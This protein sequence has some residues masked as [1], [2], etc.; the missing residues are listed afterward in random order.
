MT[1][2]A[3]PRYGPAPRARQHGQHG[4]VTEAIA[5][6]LGL[7][8]ATVRDY[9][10]GHHQLGPLVAAIVAGLKAHGE[11]ERAERLLGPIRAAMRGIVHPQLTTG[12]LLQ[13]RTADGDEDVSIV[14]FC[15][16]PSGANRRALI[17]DLDV[18]ITLKT[19]LR[20]AL[21]AEDQP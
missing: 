17:H 9:I 12:L 14:R 11:S 8:P 2:C 7:S 3:S 6:Q 15:R 19:E 16:E 21:A 4:A 18:E 10:S 13:E 20:A 1:L 5:R